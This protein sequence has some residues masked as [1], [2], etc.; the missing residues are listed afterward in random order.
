MAQV[1]ISPRTVHG[2]IHGVFLVRG[3]LKVS[4]DWCIS[5]NLFSKER[6]VN[7]REL[8]KQVYIVLTNKVMKARE[9][10]YFGTCF[11]FLLLSFFFI[12]F[13]FFFAR[14]MGCKEIT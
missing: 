6:V 1:P 10:D 11:I 3:M 7:E 2:Q 14:S 8:N 12:F 9:T 5:K 13:F 4:V